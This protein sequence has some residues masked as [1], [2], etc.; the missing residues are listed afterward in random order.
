MNEISYTGMVLSVESSFND[1]IN[2]F[3][4]SLVAYPPVNALYRNNLPDN[5]TF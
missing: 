1:S 2:E 5:S 4:T 3:I